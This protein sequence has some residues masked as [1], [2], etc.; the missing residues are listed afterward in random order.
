MVATSSY[1]DPSTKMLHI[2]KEGDMSSVGAGQTESMNVGLEDTSFEDT[3]FKIKS[4]EFKLLVYASNTAGYDGTAFTTGGDA[5]GSYLFGIGNKT[6][7]FDSFT[8]LADFQAT[9]AWPVHTSGW[10]NTVGNLFKAQKTW[11]PRK[12]ALSN[13]Q[14]AFVS[15][16][17]DLAS[18]R[19]PQSFASIYIRGIRL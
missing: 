8:E 13:E 3:K 5:F 16:S 1:Y 4:I 10:F 17:N 11:K 19:G 2:L 18:S 6:E 9:S 15:V 7:N 12:L 14:N